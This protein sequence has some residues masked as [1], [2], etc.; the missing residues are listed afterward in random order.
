[1]KFKILAIVLRNYIFQHTPFLVQVTM[2]LGSVNLLVP[3][4]RKMEEEGIRLDSLKTVLT[5]GTIASPQILKQL[6]PSFDPTIVKDCYGSTEV[7]G[8]C[9]PPMGASKGYGIGFPVS[10]AQIKVRLTK[11]AA[12]CGCHC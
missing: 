5:S 3:L 1:M 8:I 10:M 11:I 2:F 6:E 9:S 12:N 4:A 7:G